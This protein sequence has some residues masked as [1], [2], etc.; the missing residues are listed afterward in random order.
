MQISRISHVFSI[1]MTTLNSSNNNIDNYDIVPE[2]D[3]V[4]ISYKGIFKSVTS[5]YL[6]NWIERFYSSQTFHPKIKMKC[7]FRISVEL[8]QNLIHHSSS[9]DSVFFIS[10][11]HDGSACTL[12]TSN[13]VTTDQ[14]STLSSLLTVLKN[15]PESELRGLKKTVLEGESRSS[16][17]GGGMGLLDLTRISCGN[18]HYEFLPWP[19]DKD[20]LLFC[21][22]IHLHSNPA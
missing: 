14:A 12:G 19:K 18:I 20:K 8:I 6:L 15:T 5:E 7:V 3:L 4:I 9:Y 17:G 2:G 1:Y 10:K 11:S 16:H 13:P 21:L 22:T